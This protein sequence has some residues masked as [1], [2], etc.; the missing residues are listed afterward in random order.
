MDSRLISS[1][2]DA[3]THKYR[4]ITHNLANASTVAYKRRHNEFSLSETAQQDPSTGVGGTLEVNTTVDLA[5]G[6][7]V[8]TGRSLDFAINGPGFF[9]VE[10]DA[11]RV[12]TRNGQFRVSAD[13]TLVDFAGRAVAS[14]AGGPIKIPP[15]VPPSAV[16]VS[17]DGTLRYKAT[18]IGK[19][20]IVAADNP[21]DLAP[22]GDSSF[23]QAGATE[24]HKAE[25]GF[26]VKQGF[27]EASNVS[28]VKE[29]VD[30]I[31]V[32]RMYEANF[33]SIRV[34]DERKKQI[35]DVAMS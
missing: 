35:L 31:T 21:A 16:H 29:L 9:V 3:L 30:L 15:N 20:A 5:Q 33:R 10:T 1:S 28:V 11:G 26:D 22:I 34:D 19:L 7:L 13:R 27:N 17:G 25:K 18:A 14:D 6:H 4:E 32:S 12:Y 8:S 2:L 24:P 23:R